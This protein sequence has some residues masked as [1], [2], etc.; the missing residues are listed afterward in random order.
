[1][2]RG[3][4]AFVFAV[5][6]SCGF[7][8]AGDVLIRVQAIESKAKAFTDPPKTLDVKNV[9]PDLSLE[10]AAPIGGEFLAE[11][12]V[13]ERKVALTGTVK[14]SGTDPYRLSV[15]FSDKDGKGQ[16]SLTTFVEVPLDRGR[17]TGTVLGATG[18]RT[19]VLTVSPKP[20]K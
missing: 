1:M 4:A 19:I 13:G 11:M 10:T 2:T 16:Q 8:R 14:Q 15:D 20:A 7:A 6:I 18:T 5:V 3:V 17:D 12:T 9:K